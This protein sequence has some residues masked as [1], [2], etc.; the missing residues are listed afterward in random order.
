MKAYEVYKSALSLLGYVDSDDRIVPDNT[1]Y[2]RAIAIINQT[3]TDL[4]QNEIENMNS[5]I[6]ISKSCLEALIW[7]VA[8]LLSI[9]TADADKNRVFTS[10][11]NSKR[12]AALC[13][14]ETIEDKL[15]N[16]NLGEI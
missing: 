7:G 11:Y 2:K 14:A 10:I 8:M 1:L 16:V 4:K 3:L 12:T 9:S 5:E 13:E 6:N 15:P